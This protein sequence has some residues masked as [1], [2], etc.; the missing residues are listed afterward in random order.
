MVLGLFPFFFSVFFCVDLIP[1]RVR[2]LY[3][4][5]NVFIF[6]RKQFKIIRRPAYDM[7]V[8]FREGEGDSNV[9]K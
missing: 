1:Y 4:A 3:A 6:L 8:P 7:E 5:L 9:E 2:V